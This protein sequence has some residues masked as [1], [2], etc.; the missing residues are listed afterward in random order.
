MNLDAGLVPGSE[1]PDHD[2]R[3]GVQDRVGDQLGD[4]EL[5]GVG[6]VGASQDGELVDHPRAGATDCLGL[7]LKQQGAHTD[8]LSARRDTSLVTTIA[9]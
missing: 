4:A 6:E 2:R 8:L 3:V 5:G 9:M 7:G 1:E